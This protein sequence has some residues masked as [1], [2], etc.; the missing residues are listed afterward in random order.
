MFDRHVNP[1]RPL[2]GIRRY[3][4][5]RLLAKIVRMRFWVEHIDK[6]VYSFI[7]RHGDFNFLPTESIGGGPP[8][9]GFTTMGSY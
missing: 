1:N 6:I 7:V 5:I 2:S 9:M 8:T 3:A 4:A